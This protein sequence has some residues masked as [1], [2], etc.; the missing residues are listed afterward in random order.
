[1]R[2]KKHANKNEYLLTEDGIWI[3]NFCKK[4]TKAI[5]VN[6]LSNETDHKIFLHNEFLNVK[7]RY[8][9]IEQEH[10]DFSHLVIVSDG[11]DFEKKQELLLTLEGKIV[12]MAVNGALK[13]WKL[14]DKNMEKRRGI[15]CFVI[16]HPNI[17]CMSYLPKNNYYPPCIAST[18][19][20]PEFLQSY[21]NVK[22]VYRSTPNPFYSGPRLEGHFYIDDYRNPICAGIHLAQKFGVKKLLLFCCDD[23]FKDERPSAVQL[24]NKLW[25]YPQQVKGQRVIDGMLYWLNK[26]EVSIGYHSNGIKFNNATYISENKLVEFFKEEK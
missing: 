17:S 9:V 7:Q 24:E 10:Y 4:Y 14:A 20:N 18:R 26:T 25:T 1:M 13:K 6:N 8:A 11:Y 2:I 12:V 5:D 21:K 19:T 16:N 22:Y 3:R 15:S 23:S